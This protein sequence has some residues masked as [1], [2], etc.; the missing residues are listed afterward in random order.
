MSRRICEVRENRVMIVVSFGK[1]GKGNDI[2]GRWNKGPST[3]FFILER[4]EANMANM[5]T[6]RKAVGGG[7]EMRQRM[8]VDNT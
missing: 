6:A 2:G 1:G 5:I 7:K 3:I 4:S 8:T